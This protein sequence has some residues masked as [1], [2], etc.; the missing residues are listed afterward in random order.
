MSIPLVIVFYFLFVMNFT[1]SQD[2][3]DIS[4]RHSPFPSFHKPVIVGFY[5]VDVNRQMHM[6]AGNLKYLH[7]DSSSIKHDLNV[8][9][10]NYVGKKRTFENDERIDT[11][12]EWMTRQKFL[13][14]IVNDES[15]VINS[16]NFINP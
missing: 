11:L 15:Q 9:F 6:G 4:V 1:M 12:L 16:N 5:S 2:T 13:N 14:N 10:E 7:H 3:M 8:G